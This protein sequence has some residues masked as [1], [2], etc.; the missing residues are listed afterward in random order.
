MATSRET[1]GAR[2]VATQ[3]VEG[4][5]SDRIYR[6]LLGLIFLYFLF[7][8][9]FFAV[10]IAYELPPDEM[11]HIGRAQVFAQAVWVPDDGPESWEFGLIEGK[12]FLYN[13]LM[14]KVL[15]L[16]GWLPV[17][18]VLL[19]RLA[20]CVL[21]LLTVLYGLRWIRLLTPNRI[22]HL[23]FLAVITNILMFTGISA[24]VSYDNLANL[25]AAMACFYLFAFFRDRSPESL[26]KTLI[27]LCAGVF[28]KTTFLPF[29]FIVVVVLA[30]RERRALWGS[31]GALRESL[32]AS[33]S[34]R[35]RRLAL[36]GLTFALG[37]GAAGFYGINFLTYGHL[38][39]REHQILTLD[40]AMQYRIFARNY[41]V[42]QFKKGALT[43]E[44]AME[45]TRWIP[46]P[47]NQNRARNLLRVG[48]DPDRLLASLMGP[49]QY[50]TLWVKWMLSDGLGYHG[51]RVMRKWWRELLPLYMMMWVWVILFIRK[52]Q[53]GDGGGGWT[54]AAVITGFYGLVLE[55]A[56]NYRIYLRSGMMD[57]ALQGR[58]LFPVLVP[59]V[60]LFVYY[61]IA[62]LPR[63]S[64]VLVAV[65]VAAYF[66][67]GEL[68][69]FLEHADRCWFQATV[70]QCVP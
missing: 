60:G 34:V 21:G 44:Q 25:L 55:W 42:S 59:L 27:T 28:T 12:P 39:P 6:G 67:Y 29:A 17:G 66:V 58:Y 19:L 38:T 1:P 37:L 50:A 43:Y 57:Y 54:A 3:P 51:H 53:P 48:R 15:Q 24:A 56:V 33:E 14:G 65:L 40:Q 22:V 41:I 61:L 32:Q 7:K 31:W 64:Q 46:E 68:P 8:L 20:N 70:A 26:T 23:L 4:W 16:F 5:P 49:G 2:S 9:L 69:Y 13:V 52:W 18:D 47:G 63:R 10:S 11:T 36:Y 62:Y 45:M 30:V 35:R